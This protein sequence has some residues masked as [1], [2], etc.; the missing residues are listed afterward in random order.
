[1]SADSCG[2]LFVVHCF[3]FLRGRKVGNYVGNVGNCRGNAKNVENYV[4]K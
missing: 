4:E 3:P 2:A 1:V